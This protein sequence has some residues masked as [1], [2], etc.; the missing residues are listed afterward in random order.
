M[1]RDVAARIS[2]LLRELAQAFDDLALEPET[3]SRPK[4]RPQVEPTMQPSAATVDSVRRRMRRGG[5]AA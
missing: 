2:G 3:R 4:S 1:K 5:V